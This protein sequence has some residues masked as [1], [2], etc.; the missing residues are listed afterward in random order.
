MPRVIPSP[1]RW[2]GLPLFAVLF[3]SSALRAQ[4]APATP[5]PSATPELDAIL[6]A[7]GYLKP[8]PAIERAVLA[9]RHLLVNLTNVSPDGDQFLNPKS[10]GQ[11][12]IADLGKPHHNLA[13]WFVYPAGNRNRQVETRGD[14][15]LDILNWSDG[16]SVQIQLPMGATV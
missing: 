11:P 5:T 9:P 10:A 7:E 13:G 12:K 1:A 6:A 2:L 16:R 8:P 3:V 4:T 14:I 15:G